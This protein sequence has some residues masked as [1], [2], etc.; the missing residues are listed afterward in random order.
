MP[1][2][3]YIHHYV[4]VE[5]RELCFV[6]HLRSILPFSSKVKAFSNNP[7]HPATYPFFYSVIPQKLVFINL[8]LFVCDILKK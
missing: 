1:S 8:F 6:C 7:Q 4:T 5:I 3:L 2:L